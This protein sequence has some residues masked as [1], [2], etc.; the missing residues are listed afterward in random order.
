[1]HNVYY[2]KYY[3]YQLEGDLSDQDRAKLLEIANKCPVHPESGLLRS[4]V[5]H[6]SMTIL[7]ALQHLGYTIPPHADCGWIG[8]AV[9]GSS[10]RDASD[11]GPVEFDNEFTQHNTTIMTS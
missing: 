1:M 10:Y 11:D 8:E 4:R 7:H 5:K 9:P 6:S 2:V 3:I